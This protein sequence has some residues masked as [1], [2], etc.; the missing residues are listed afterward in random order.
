MQCC[1]ARS[2]AARWPWNVEWHHQPSNPSPI[3]PLFPDDTKGC[4]R[5]PRHILQYIPS[6]PRFQLQNIKHNIGNRRQ[7]A[8]DMPSTVM[9]SWPIP[10]AE[11]AIDDDGGGGG[12]SG[13]VTSALANQVR[14]ACTYYYITIQ[15]YIPR[16]RPRQARPLLHGMSVPKVSVAVSTAPPAIYCQI[17]IFWILLYIIYGVLC[18]DIYTTIYIT[19]L[20]ATVYYHIT[21]L[22]YNH[23]VLPS[24]YP[25]PSSPQTSAKIHMLPARYVLY[26]HTIYSSAVHSQARGILTRSRLPCLFPDA[27]PSRGWDVPLR[28]ASR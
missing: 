15:I 7:H 24:L 25:S 22:P 16:A 14:V 26:H 19:I 11:N 28:D 4:C 27:L 17:M 12:N 3:L 20:G 5:V 18:E 21:I 6:V 23:H 8:T 9:G 2:V 10:S 13:E 1:P